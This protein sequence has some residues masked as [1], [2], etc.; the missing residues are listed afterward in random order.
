MVSF[1]NRHQ[2]ALYLLALA[3]GVVASFVPGV[4]TLAQPLITPALSFLLLVTFLSLPLRGLLVPKQAPGLTAAL[5]LLNFLV[6]PLITA[7]LVLV[8]A[9]LVP[10][11]PDLLLF[12]AALVL[13]APCIDYVVAFAAAAGG[14][15]DRLLARTPLL[16]LTQ[17]VLVPVWILIFNRA[18]VWNRELLASRALWN[19][20]PEVGLALAV[21]VVPLA[22]AA[23]VQGI[24]PKVRSVTARLAEAVMVPA[25]LPVLF[26][27]PAAHA[28]H[29]THWA[30]HIL[31]LASIYTVFAILMW[32]LSRL[33]L[34]RYGS[35]LSTAEQT[36]ATFSAVTRNALVVLP[37]VLGLSAAMG[38]TA[39]A[40]LMPLAVLT[41]TL[42]ELLILTLM[43]AVYR[44]QLSAPSSPR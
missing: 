26:L 21:V 42:V 18:G 43:V 11:L 29:L 8:L 34:P 16:L 13:L 2:V 30:L 12:T 4:A 5:V 22:L 39:G 32:G 24:G 17:C 23:V 9:V 35:C 31:P 38:G 44:N 37:I 25:M 15:S 36:A 33:L 14:A 19:S 7:A 10:E 40:S 20:L 41:Q 3:G 1:M 28:A 27:T 6:V